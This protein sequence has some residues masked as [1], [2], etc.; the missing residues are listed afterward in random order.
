MTDTTTRQAERAA[1]SDPAQRVKV[2]RDRMRRGDLSRER[3][4]LAAYCGNGVAREVVGPMHDALPEV[5]GWTFTGGIP[6][7]ERWTKGLQRWG[8]TVQVRAGLAAAERAWW[9]SGCDG[10]AAEA[11]DAVQAWLD[12]PSEASRQRW[13]EAAESAAGP[14]VRWILRPS[15]DAMTLRARVKAAAK[16][17]SEEGVRK[18]MQAALT[19]WA[20][21]EVSHG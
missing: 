21:G 7:L 5:R 10:N 13:E 19:G 14:G 3:V 6:S 8:H 9:A 20:L 1:L 18:A 4:E 17:T 16:A 11:L 2:L 15:D 12:N